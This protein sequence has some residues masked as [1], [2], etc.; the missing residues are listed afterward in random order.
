VRLHAPA[1]GDRDARILVGPGHL[2][3]TG[4]GLA[5]PALPP[6]VCLTSPS[7]NVMKRHALLPRALSLC[8]LAFLVP[9]PAPAQPTAFFEAHCYACHTRDVHKGGLDLAALRAEPDNP[10]N[11]A[12][13]A[14]VHD[15]IEAGEMPPA[16]RYRPPA[17]ETAAALAALREI[18]AKAE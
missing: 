14:R 8:L 13:W 15:R 9:A 6:A 11:F 7:R 10:E 5:R 3:R 4:D 1:P 16:K 12:R 2:P 17:A 18:L